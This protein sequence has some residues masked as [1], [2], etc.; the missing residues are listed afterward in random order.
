M[1]RILRAAHVHIVLPNQFICI[2][3]PV[4]RT[5]RICSSKMPKEPETVLHEFRQAVNMTKEELSE[6]LKTSDSTAVG[7][8]KNDG[9][10]SVG[11]ESGRKIVDMLEKSDEELLEDEDDLAHMRRVVSYVHRHIAQRHKLQHDVTDSK[12]RYSL[13]NWCVQ[14]IL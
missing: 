13:M 3:K 5:V 12:W 2:P 10:E 11:H 1:Q 14:P 9:G 8:G 6:Y 7:W 4:A